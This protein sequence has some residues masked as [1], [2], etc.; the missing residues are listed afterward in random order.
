MRILLV[1]GLAVRQPDN[2]AQLM[3]LQKAQI[4]PVFL[5]KKARIVP[6]DDELR[7]EMTDFV[8]K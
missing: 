8:A 5:A 2:K 1:W 3:P 6:D 4:K 7:R